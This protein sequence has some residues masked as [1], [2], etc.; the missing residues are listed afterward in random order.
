MKIINNYSESNE[1]YCF[2]LLSNCINFEHIEDREYI[3]ENLKYIEKEKKSLSK[4]ICDDID[5][6]INE[7]INP[8]IYDSNYFDFMY[9]AEYGVFD[10]NN[11]FVI[12]S[13]QALDMLIYELYNHTINLHEKLLKIFAKHIK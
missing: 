12:K 2:M 7:V 4:K 3:L 13:E 10:K 5:K 11:H 1:V 6:F 8:I 9:K